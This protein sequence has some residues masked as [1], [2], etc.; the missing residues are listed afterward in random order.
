MRRWRRLA[1]TAAVA[2]AV[3]LAAALG[4]GVVFGPGLRPG[5]Q[6]QE[7]ADPYFPVELP[8]DVRGRLVVHDHAWPHPDPFADPNRFQGEQAETWAQRHNLAKGATHGLSHRLTQMAYF[9]PR[10]RHRRFRNMYFAGAST[11]PGTGVPTAMASGRLAA[12]RIA[13]EQG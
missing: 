2:M 7:P 11:H 3:G 9:R 1:L 6:R 8:P 12:R 4:S 10:N 13:A 5:G